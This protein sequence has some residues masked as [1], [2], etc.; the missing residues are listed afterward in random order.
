MSCA[1]RRAGT[2]TVRVALGQALRPM[3]VAP[4][5]P[6]APTYGAEVVAALRFCW[7]VLGA[8]TGKRLAPVLGELVATLRRFEELDVSDEVAGALMVMSAATMDR[9]LAIRAARDGQRPGQDDHERHP[10]R[11]ELGGD[12][13]PDPS[14]DRAAPD[15]DDEQGLMGIHLR[16]NVHGT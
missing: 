6:R 10:A 12:P 7:A 13:T 16:A 1:R 3:V 5:R 4:R 14:P 2:V 9:R 8:P 15:P 11:A